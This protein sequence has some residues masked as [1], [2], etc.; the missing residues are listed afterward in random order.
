[1]CP[2]PHARADLIDPIGGAILIEAVMRRA[3]VPGSLLVLLFVLIAEPA[4]AAW[5]RVPT[6]NLPIC[7]A[8]GD[9][10]GSVA[11]AD[12]S[13]GVL[14]AWVD[15]RGGAGYDIYAQHVLATGVVDPAWPATGRAICTATNDQT[16]PA[17]LSDGQGG[18]LIAWA[19]FRGGASSDIYAQHVLASGVVDPAWPVNGRA[20]CLAADLQQFPGLVTDGAG[21]AIVAWQDRRNG[22]FGTDD[23]YAQHVLASGAV[24]GAWPV[25]GRALCT[26]AS[27][28]ANLAIGTDGAGGAIV[29]WED[30]RSGTLDIYA[31][32]VLLSGTVDTNWPFNGRAVCT[33]AGAQY[34]PRIAADGFGNAIIAW[35]DARG[36]SYDIYAQ[37][38]LVT[39]N[40]DATW[41]ANGAVLCAAA[42]DQTGPTIVADGAGGAIVAWED[43][44]SGT[45]YDVYAQHV[46]E[47]GSVDPAWPVDGRALTLAALNQYTAKAASDGAGGAIVVWYD[48]RSGSDGD[49]YA[50]H[51]T[52]GGTLDVNWPSNGLAIAT[53]TSEVNNWNVVSDGSNG[54]I[55]VW[56]DPRNGNSDIYGERVARSGFLGSPE[57][58]IASVKDVPSDQGGKVK[59]SFNASYLEADPYDVVNYYMVYRS[60]PPNLAAAML[61]GGTRAAPLEESALGGR[62][63]GELFVTRTSA[64]TFYWEYVGTVNANFLTNYS[65]L[66]PTVED[67]TAG[68]G[69]PQTAIMIQARSYSGF[70][71]ESAPMSGYSVDNLGPAA[72][73]PFTGQYLAGTTHLHWNPNGE[74]DLFGYRLYRGVT[75]GFVPGPANL[76]A[77][78]ADTG[79]ADAAGAPYVY[80]LVAV[81]IHGNVSPISTLV[82]SGTTAVGEP[83]PST[84]LALAATPNPAFAAVVFRWSLPRDGEV[85]L[86]VYDAAGRLVRDLAKGRSTAGTH[87]GSWDLRDATGREVGAGLYFARIE[88]AGLARTTRIAVTR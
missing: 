38:V 3:F 72:P 50:Q 54:A 32:R 81:D 86:A 6:L 55:F 51:V 23:I 66:V 22:G 4:D 21:G 43:R 15:S 17:I 56:D 36:A 64:T 84:E 48:T 11:T 28:Q 58:E 85:R 8:T 7:T 73:V 16:E 70:H 59:V 35:Q 20:L 24:D 18:A 78:P 53:A 14:I 68:G 63:P 83:G 69:A 39:G 19:D 30:N 40:V 45:N 26:A 9:Q 88:A 33:A 74:S 65:T 1:M 77:S 27:S 87:A 76:V 42:N 67:S 57:A 75:T 49:L 52:S 44:R 80:K 34:N 61:R 13:G 47:A 60:V 12:G 82:P 71:W 79:F 10:L 25:D 46:L 5:P 41:P 37:R 31:Q 29:T 62:R 2:A